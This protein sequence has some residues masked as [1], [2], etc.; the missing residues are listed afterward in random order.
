MSGDGWERFRK[1]VAAASAIETRAVENPATMERRFEV[2]RR[3]VPVAAH[4]V[5]DSLLTAGSPQL[6][7]ELGNWAK[8]VVGRE[9]APVAAAMADY[10]WFPVADP[11]Q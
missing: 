8:A 5:S 6:L 7:D 3:G 11:P 9:F 4:V 1:A 2:T 10:L